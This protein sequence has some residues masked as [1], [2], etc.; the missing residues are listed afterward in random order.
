MILTSCNESSPEYLNE[1]LSFEDRVDDLVNRMTLAEKIEQLRYDAPANDRLGIPAYNWWNECLHGV[2]RSGKATVFPQ[3]IG[4]AAT[5]NKSL[6]FDV[7]T[8]ISDEARG[9]YHDYIRKDKHGIY[10]GLTFWTPNINIF[11]DPRWGRGMETYG[12]DPFLTSQIAI[13]FIKGLQGDHPK[14][15]KAIATVKHFAVHSGPEP[16]RHSFNADVS[17]QDLWETYL[18]HFRDCIMETNVQ[19]VMCAYNLYKENPCCGNQFLLEEVLRKEW[20]FKGYV[21]SDCWALSDFY[22]FQK[23]AENSPQA[24]AIALKAGTD[25][26]CGVV[27]RD[28]QQAVDSNLV[29]EEFVDTAVK[30]LMLARFRLGM[31]DNQ[32]NIPWSN[33][34]VEILDNKAHKS[35]ALKTAEESMVL[36]KNEKQTLPLSK[37]IKSIAVIGPNANNAEVMFANYNGTPTNPVT[38]FEGISRLA[39]N[40]VSV[41]Y[42]LGCDWAE[43][44]PF[45]ETVSSEYLRPEENSEKRG[46]LGKYF[47]NRE[48]KGDP[49]FTRVDTIIDFNWWDKAPAPELDEDNFAIEWS[50]YIIAPETG[51]YY[52]GA[53]GTEYEVYLGDSLLAQRA[54][55]HGSFPYYKKVML[56]ENQKYAIRILQKEEDGESEVRLIW[57]RPERNLEKEALNLAKE[58]DQVVLFMGL[59]PWL[60]GE[61]MD[62]EVEG[63][64]GGDRT[65]IDLPSMQKD[66]IKKVYDVN[67]NIV[68]VLMNGSALAINWCDEH[69]PAILEAWY[70]G[71][72]GGTAIANILFGKANPSGR[73]PLTFYKTVND[74]PPFDDYN[75]QGRTYKY[76]KGVPLYP[77]GYGLSYTTFDYDNLNIQNNDSALDIRFT[78]INSGNYDGDEVIQVYAGHKESIQFYPIRKLIAFEKISLHAGEE[79]E[80][81]ISVPYKNLAMADEK[82]TFQISPEEY[83]ISVGGGQ[84]DKRFQKHNNFISETVSIKNRHTFF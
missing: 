12:E 45:M 47:S 53:Y 65:A 63:F 31:F 34:P 33:I 5:W 78:I 2:A 72:D 11:R 73:L 1:S 83:I 39:G 71:Q 17:D 59:S 84:P 3:A 80:M 14:Y 40:T 6:I 20:G 32:K 57:S 52:I 25:L 16:E 68:L 66:F 49:A 82:G 9:K 21:V 30:R 56:K 48:M 22:T 79:R 13:P 77:F 67:P 55:P 18:P 4:L 29:D 8:V 24:G 10:Q 28:L 46:L 26:N 69:I 35:M 42:A 38:P 27:Y 7:A 76:F 51:E 61:Q 50:G 43:N 60:E 41:K 44:M 37:D 81:V 54:Q 19:S 64:L 15:L 58:S 62:V 70:P 75:M 36:L 74:L 23:T